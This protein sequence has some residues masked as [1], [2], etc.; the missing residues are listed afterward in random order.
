MLEAFVRAGSER[1]NQNRERLAKLRQGYKDTEASI[2]RLLGL[3]EQGIM[4]A[5]DPS[6]RE[7]LI[8]LKVQRDE[9]AKD[10]ADLQRRMSTGE[11]QITPEKI[12]RLSIL[13]RDK[14]HH[15]EPEFRQAY[16]R[17]IMEEVTVSD[18]EIC[19]SGSKAVLARCAAAGDT[20]AAP[21]V[22]SFVQE[23]RA[24][25]D[26]NPWPLPSEGNALSS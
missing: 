9:R 21:A 17:L 24:R 15:G 2:A 22:L 3:V 1:E 13:L 6:L 12:E 20:P 26:S 19:I 16:A 4:E 11:P 18:E 10:A 5:G 8:G 7:R 14:L 23:W 25:R